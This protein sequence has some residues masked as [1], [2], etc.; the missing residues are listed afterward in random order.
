MPKGPVE[1]KMSLTEEYIKIITERPLNNPLDD[2]RGK[3]RDNNACDPRQE[4]IAG[5]L[6]ILLGTP[7]AFSLH[8]PDG[9]GNV[10]FKLFSIQQQVRAGM[11][12]LAYFSPLFAMLSTNPPILTSGKL[13][14]T[15]SAS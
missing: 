1:L 15:S 8:C 9:S 14:S 2:F 7:A 6:A 3:L 11:V 5:L 12:I 4:N 13:F 10:A